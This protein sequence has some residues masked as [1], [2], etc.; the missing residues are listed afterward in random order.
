MDD[1]KH[2]QRFSDLALDG[3]RRNAKMDN[4]R[5]AVSDFYREFVQNFL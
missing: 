4:Q 3:Y 1:C 2:S 5:E